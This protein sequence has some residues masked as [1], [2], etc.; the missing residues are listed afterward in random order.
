MMRNDPDLN[1]SVIT[2]EHAHA[3][4]IKGTCFFAGLLVCLFFAWDFLIWANDGFLADGQRYFDN[5]LGRLVGSA[6]C[7]LLGFMFLIE[8]TKHIFSVWMVYVIAVLVQGDTRKIRR[9]TR[10][11]FF[12]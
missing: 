3:S 9:R 6:F 2:R 1:V 8:A 5:S 10:P 7:T 11:N 4:L 12:E